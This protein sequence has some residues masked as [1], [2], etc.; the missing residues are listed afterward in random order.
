MRGL[1]CVVL[2]GVTVTQV[3]CKGCKDEETEVKPT[4]TDPGE[5]HDIG[6]WLSMR[7]TVDGH[8]AIAY[9]DRTSDALG[10]A[11][12][13]LGGSGVTWVSEEVD[14]YPSESG[15]NPGD[16][17]KYASL[18]FA[19]DGSAW[20]VYQDVSNGTLKYA[21]K[22]ADTNDGAWTVGIAD[23]G[24]GAKSDAG[25]WASLAFDKSGN[26][27]AVHYDKGSQA[28]R[29]ARWDGSAFKGMVI[30]EGTDYVPADTGA[31]TVSANV[32]EYAK[33]LVDGDVEY[34][35]YYDRAN[36]DL[37]LATGSGST[38]SVATIDGAAGDVGM[39]PDLAVSGSDL[40]VAYQDV[41]TQNLRLAVGSG[42]S[43]TSELVDT[44][45]YTGADTVLWV[46]GSSPGI[47]YFDGVN[48]DQKL[49][50]KN[51]STWE[52]ETVTGNESARGYHNESVVVDGKRYSAC[53]D[54]TTREVWFAE[55]P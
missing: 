31:D 3:G 7:V 5:P 54:Y 52:I 18:G 37:K 36:G 23:T 26:P 27:V 46:D 6:S 30:D 33:I 35:A 20:I 34:I 15:M 47:L 40:Y 14:S 10:Y 25:Y 45:A 11:E 19:P 32:G 41:T 28:L 22:E 42:S 53:Y 9:Y 39:W 24:S 2:L 48:N 1:V 21:H 13:T 4:V 43:F 17:G 38:F 29:L 16:A 50:R 49:A 55:L 51:G 44:A 8:P 12:G